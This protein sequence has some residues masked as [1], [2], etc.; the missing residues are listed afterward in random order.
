MAEIPAD[1]TSKESKRLSWDEFAEAA[2][3]GAAVDTL[4]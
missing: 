1:S 3:R 2:R 4:L